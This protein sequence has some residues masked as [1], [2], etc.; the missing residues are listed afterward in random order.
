MCVNSKF[1]QGI[2]FIH[3]PKKNDSVNTRFNIQKIYNP[4]E[5]SMYDY[6]PPSH[7]E[8]VVGAT[9]DSKDSYELGTGV[10]RKR[11]AENLK[12]RI[13][14]KIKQ[15][16]GWCSDFKAG[17]LMEL[18]WLMQPQVVVEVGVFG[19]KSLVPM[20]F[21]LK[22]LGSGVA[23]GIDPWS[24]GASAEG[25]DGANK[26]WWGSLDHAAILAKLEG[27]ITLF[28]LNDYVQLVQ[29]TSEDAAEIPNIDILHIDG[30]HSNDA[31]Y[32]DA[33][34]W[35]PLVRRGGMIIFDDI[36]WGTTERATEWLDENC[37]RVITMKDVE[38]EWAI[39][40]K[41]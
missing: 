12:I 35:V 2:F 31:S 36:T 39:W 40:V 5:F 14:D 6:I 15:L 29:A 30:N 16:D 10:N 17:T 28:G 27:K 18:V 21:A 24:A 22:A 3:D 19:G 41:S 7:Y 34:K 32:Y 38:N 23:Y 37:V 33:L 8:Y 20:A 1:C 9:N 25:M 26:D 4:E 13:L 11:L